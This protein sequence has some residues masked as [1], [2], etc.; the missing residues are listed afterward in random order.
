MDTYLVNSENRRLRSWGKI[1]FQLK[2]QFDNWA[3]H[4]LN[5]FGYN[6]F[7]MGHMPFIM[8]INPEGITNNELAK[9]ARVT[10]QAMSKVVKELN[11]FGYINVKVDLND[12]RSAIIFLTDKGKKFV[13]VAR[14]KVF[15]LEE[16]YEKLLGKKE[17]ELLK[18]M[19]LRIAA[20]NDNIEK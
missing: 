13:V 11:E 3:I 9:I 6:D 2:R 5:S 18:D 10:K 7:K 20:Y 14:Q 1:L 8:N 4:E 16:R 19:L 17:F 15:E 12:K